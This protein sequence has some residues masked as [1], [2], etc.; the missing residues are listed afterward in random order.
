M[1]FSR[2]YYKLKTLQYIRVRFFI[3]N[4]FYIYIFETDLNFY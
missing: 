4:K 2:Y 3:K 1:L